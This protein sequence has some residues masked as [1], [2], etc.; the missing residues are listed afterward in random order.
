MAGEDNVQPVVL[1]AHC[2]PRHFGL[3][4][5]LKKLGHLDDDLIES[6][7]WRL[8]SIVVVSVLWAVLLFGT[9]FLTTSYLYDFALHGDDERIA[10]KELPRPFDPLCRSLHQ[11]VYAEPWASPPLR[12]DGTIGARWSKTFQRI[13]AVHTYMFLANILGFMIGVYNW[14]KPVDLFRLPAFVRQ[15][16]HPRSKVFIFLCVN[17]PVLSY[18]RAW[19]IGSLV[20]VSPF[21]IV[22]TAL[23]QLV[24]HYL[25][26][27]VSTALHLGLTL[28]L[29]IFWAT[30]VKSEWAR[31]L[32]ELDTL[33]RLQNMGSMQIVGERHV[34]GKRR[35]R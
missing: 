34:L 7:H 23:V 35:P 5:D 6:F 1:D 12:Y 16:L 2:A 9:L 25:T 20:F 32:K 8:A 29:A 30:A 10:L 26:S 18:L 19:I 22:E 27:F 33:W 17:P 15:Y 14:V 31:I 28:A 21:E 13:Q 24:Y 11:L 4:P 3:V